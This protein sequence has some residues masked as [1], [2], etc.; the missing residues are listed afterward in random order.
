MSS[1]NVRPQKKLR[2][3]AQFAQLAKLAK[4]QKLHF[5]PG[6]VVY[7]SALPSQQRQSAPATFSADDIVIP[8]IARTHRKLVARRRSS[9]AS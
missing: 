8:K 3:L 5:G 4:F 9:T 1:K 2:A 7:Y 6:T